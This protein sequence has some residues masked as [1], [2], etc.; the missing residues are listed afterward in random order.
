MSY[1]PPN[2]NAIRI[3]IGDGYT[4]PDNDALDF[5]FRNSVTAKSVVFD[6][7]SNYGGTYVGIRSIEFKLAGVLIPLTQSDFTADSSSEYS[8]DYRAELA[9]DTTTLKTGTH[10][11]RSWMTGA[12]SSGRVLVTFDT[13]QEFD[14]I[15]IN[16]FHV[17]GA[18]TTIGAKSVRVIITDSATPSNAFEGAIAQQMQLWVGNLTQHPLTDTAED[19]T[20]FNGDV[21]YPRRPGGYSDTYVKATSKWGTQYEPWFG[22][23]PSLKLLGSRGDT[24]WLTPSGVYTNQKFNVDLGTE[25]IITRFRMMNQHHAGNDTIYGI[26]NFTIYGTNSAT[27]FAN[28]TYSNTD[29]LTSLGDFVLD[30]YTTTQQWDFQDFDLS[31]NTT[32]YR[33]YVLRIADGYGTTFIGFRQ[34]ELLADT[35]FY[36]TVQLTA[37]CAAVSATSIPVASVKTGLVASVGAVSS[38]SIAA[39]EVTSGAVQLTASCDAASSTPTATGKVKAPLSAAVSAASNTPTVTGKV[40]AQL[41]AS[42]AASSN[43]PAIAGKIKVPL[44][45]AIHAASNTS[46]AEGKVLG[47]VSLSA[48]CTAISNTQIAAGK[49]TQRLTADIS[50]LSNTV[51][52]A[53][54]ITAPL[55]A[56]INAVSST[57]TIAG[58]TKGFLSASIVAESDTS[59]VA[60]KL[61]GTVNLIASCAAISNTQIAAGKLKQRLTADVAASSN[62]TAAAG[63]IKQRLTASIF[64]IS[65]TEAAEALVKNGASINAVSSTSIAQASVRPISSCSLI[66]FTASAP[67]KSFRREAPIV[68][69]SK[70]YPAI[71]FKKKPSKTC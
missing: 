52:A 63:R 16:N 15:V 46:V 60:G 34:L 37:S 33:Y 38:T 55:S 2:N 59:L 28:T 1:T 56:D 3:V 29:N 30:E 18:T 71:S 21:Y 24:S 8:S 69:F 42:I 20:T 27:A 49:V 13:P 19:E 44:S 50:A 32:A 57:P 40:K 36:T 4:T 48:E 25:E 5:T 6:V 14:E 7:A 53:A 12:A 61:F 26:K 22:V 70:P 47:K 45:V 35:K 67:D 58:T 39:G 54:K 31:S 41:S 66:A 68:S 23:D 51:A 65:Q 43:T 62:T 11:G 9:F 64:A 10:V 17:S